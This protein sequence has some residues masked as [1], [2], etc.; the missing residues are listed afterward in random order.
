MADEKVRLEPIVGEAVYIM[1]PHPDA[2][3]VSSNET[4]TPGEPEVAAETLSDLIAAQVQTQMSG[5]RSELQAE[6]QIEAKG[7]LDL[8]AKG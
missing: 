4:V 5:L 3:V 7:G 1:P 8:N 6:L 2:H